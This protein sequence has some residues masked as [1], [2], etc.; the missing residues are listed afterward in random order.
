MVKKNVATTD[1]KPI[2]LLRLFG[3]LLLRAAQ[4]VLLSL[5]LKEPPRNTRSP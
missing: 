5:L 3:L 2:L 1:R 4:R